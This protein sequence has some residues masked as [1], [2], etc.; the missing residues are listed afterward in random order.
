MNANITKMQIF[1]NIKL[2]NWILEILGKIFP[3]FDY[4]E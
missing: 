2:F 1:D 4:E 3:F